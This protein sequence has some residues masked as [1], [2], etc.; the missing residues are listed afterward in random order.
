[1]DIALTVQ[2]ADR[3][4]VSVD[5]AGAGFPVFPYRRELPHGVSTQQRKTLDTVRVDASAELTAFDLDRESMM[6][7]AKDARVYLD[8]MRGTPSRSTSATLRSRFPDL[9]DMCGEVHAPSSVRLAFSN[10]LPYVADAL[11]METGLGVNTAVCYRIRMLASH[12][13][14]LL[15][16]HRK[17]RSRRTQGMNTRMEE[18]RVS[19]AELRNEVARMMV[20]D[21]PG[22]QEVVQ[23]IREA[24]IDA[25]LYARTAQAI[26][27]TRFVPMY[28]DDSYLF[29]EP[30]TTVRKL[31]LIHI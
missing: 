14:E 28:E 1:M 17:E 12:E 22:F 31:S 20:F 19:I 21:F 11:S 13:E 6:H 16:L 18:L 25:S 15:R 30:F 3:L 7:T 2:C 9:E 5:P 27:S 26:A 8:S 29:W 24:L 23:R 4:G 10:Q